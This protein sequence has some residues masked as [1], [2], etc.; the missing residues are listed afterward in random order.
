MTFCTNSPKTTRRP[1]KKIPEAA[2]R[3]EI[4]PASQLG[5]TQRQ[6]E[7][8]QFGAIQASVIPPEFFVTVDERFEILAAPGLVSFDHQKGNALPQIRG[9]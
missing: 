5:S 3:L 8:I 2:L 6:I 9:R 7:G 4:Y 1:S